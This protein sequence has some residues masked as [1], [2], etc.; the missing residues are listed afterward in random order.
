MTKFR[1]GVVAV[2][3]SVAL[4][5]GQSVAFADRSPDNIVEVRNTRDYS[6]QSRS[7]GVVT[8]APGGT[9]GNNNVATAWATCLECRTTA[10]AVQMVIVEGPY[11][12]LEPGNLA[13]AINDNCDTCETFAYARQY[14]FIVG[15]E[16]KISHKAETR[17][18]RIDEDM[19]DVIRSRDDFP[20]MEAE[21]DA[22]T[23]QMVDVVRGEID[24]TG[25]KGGEEDHRDV[26]KHDRHD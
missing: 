24:R 10:A 15:R 19:E 12:T 18:E 21:L 7:R 4:M 13:A 14:V 3:M 20:T 8:H 23:Q 16:V 2:V 11:D 26:E 6:F 5:G 25:N 9:V 17:I 22:L 1:V